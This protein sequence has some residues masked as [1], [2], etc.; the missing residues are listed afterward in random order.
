MNDENRNIVFFDATCLLCNRS[1]QFLLQH[2][3]HNRLY[4]ATLQSDVAKR[5][6]L[7]APPKILEQD[8]I[9]FFYNQQF[10][11]KSD[12]ILKIAKILG[13][14]FLIS[15][16]LYIIPKPLRDYIYTLI[17]KNRYRWFGKTETCIIADEEIKDKFL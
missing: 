11:A 12:A 14:K 9:I 3:Q 5:L 16:I 6:L 10:Y 2:D 15:Q 13:G 7:Q 8:S 4:F 1:V 17:A